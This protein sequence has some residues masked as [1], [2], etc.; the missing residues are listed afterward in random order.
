MTIVDVGAGA[1]YFTFKLSRMVGDDGQVIATDADREMVRILRAE[2]QERRSSNV[3]VKHVEHRN[4]LEI[5]AEPTSV[6]V[7]LAVNVFLFSSQGI[8][9]R[10]LGNERSAAYLYLAGFWRALKPG[11]RAVIVNDTVRTERGFLSWSGDDIPQSAV[12]EIASELFEIVR[13]QQVGVDDP[14]RYPGYLLVLR[15]PD[16]CGRPVGCFP[17]KSC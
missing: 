4:P 14:G 17:G 1:G 13:Q 5:G 16:T 12:V 9:S 2:K 6:D 8:F 11:G 10:F 15:K 7:V 3:A